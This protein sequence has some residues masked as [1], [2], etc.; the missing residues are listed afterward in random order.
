LCSMKRLYNCF[1]V[2]LWVKDATKTVQIYIFMSKI[3]LVLFTRTT[4]TES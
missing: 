2:F 1:I 4:G 3:G